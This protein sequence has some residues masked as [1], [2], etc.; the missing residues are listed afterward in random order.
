MVEL[1]V[2]SGLD[3]GVELMRHY[4]SECNVLTN[5]VIR[6][7]LCVCLGE[8]LMVEGGQMDGFRQLR[9]KERDKRG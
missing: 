5:I 7:W 8:F 9:R 4:T 3:V 6:C 1:K 2:G